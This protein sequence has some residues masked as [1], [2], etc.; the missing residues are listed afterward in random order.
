MPSVEFKT[1]I[2]LNER[3]QTHSLDHAATGIAS[4]ISYLFHLAMEQYH[5][6]Q[7]SEN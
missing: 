5:K 1:P 4:S 6:E 7:E 2:P 3:S